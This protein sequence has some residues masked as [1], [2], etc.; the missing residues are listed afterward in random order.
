MCKTDK[1]L[2]DQFFHTQQIIHCKKTGNKCR[3]YHSQYL[4]YIRQHDIMYTEQYMNSTL[5]WYHFEE[6]GDD[7]AAYPFCQ[8]NIIFLFNAHGSHTRLLL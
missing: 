7:T 8:N 5:A 1:S 3:M 2:A 6:D 4:L